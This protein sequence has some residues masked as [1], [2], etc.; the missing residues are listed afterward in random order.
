VIKV[1]DDGPAVLG[2]VV[3]LAL[4]VGLRSGSR[5]G[6]LALEAAEVRHVLLAPIDRGLAL[7]APAVRQVRFALFVG[8]VVGA[9]GGQLAAR[10]LPHP[11]MAWVVCGFAFGVVTAALVLGSA[12]SAAAIKL[13]SWIAGVVGLALVAWAA[14]DVAGWFPESPTAF[15]GRIALFP[16]DQSAEVALPVLVAAGLVVFGIAGL[17]SVSLESA[18]RRSS[19]VGQLRFAATLQDIRTVMV[20]RRQLALELPRLRPWVRVG[21]GRLPVLRRDAQGVTRWPA[22][23]VV[24]LV[25]LSVIAGLSARAA[26]DGAVPMVIVAGLALY[27]AGLDMIEPLAQEIDHPGLRDT[28]PVAA[29]PLHL[30]HLPSIALVAVPAALPGA[31]VAVA[32]EPTWSAAAVAGIVAVSAGLAA[33]A[34]ATVSVLMG[35]PAAADSWSLV[36]PEIAGARL[37]GRTVWPPALAVLGVLP[38][39]AARAAAHAKPP[40]S[41]M[42][43]ATAAAL[44]VLFVV[45]NVALWVRYRDQAK[46]WWKEKLA[47]AFPSSEGARAGG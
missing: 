24:R 43:P 37:A 9:V 20:L 44:G 31:A 13:P 4:F 25:V 30:R 12:L 41:P 2:V 28:Y 6:P 36:P 35:A 11:F 17:G 21:R 38:V 15:V 8:A 19:L 42:G 3:A 32:I 34:G 22:S 27:V 23:R 40:L 14:G 47:Q 26:W 1:A 16:L 46:A 10:R 18:E 45:A 33:A 39:V 5:G 29:G 7:R